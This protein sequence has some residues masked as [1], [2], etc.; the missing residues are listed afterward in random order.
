MRKSRF[1]EAQIVGIL[2][3][4]KAGA[5]AAELCRKHGIS[6]ATLYN[7]RAKYGGLEVSDLVRLKELEDENR[8]L[9]KIVADQALNIEAL[10][11]RS[12]PIDASATTAIDPIRPWAGRRPRSSPARSKSV[13][14]STYPRW[15]DGATVKTSLQYPS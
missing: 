15:H 4:L 10:K 1:S 6:D 13:Q 7:W 8:R 9:K 11:M 12:S 5:K 14:L 3:E 2:K